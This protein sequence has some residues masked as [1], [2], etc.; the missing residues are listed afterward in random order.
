MPTLTKLYSMQE[1]SEHNSAGDCWIV[2][3]GKV[4]DVSSYL[5]E[6][7]GGDDVILQVTGKDATDEFEDAGHSKS[8]RE[9]METFCVGELDPSDIPQLEVVSEKQKGYIPEKLVDLS[10]QYW[11]APVAVVGIS[12][13][14]TFLYLR[15][16]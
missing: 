14:V 2:V 8:A 10:K 9:L 1:A 6:H 4:Y 12:V 11:A 15:N 3:D 16:K 5:E 13:V 7:P